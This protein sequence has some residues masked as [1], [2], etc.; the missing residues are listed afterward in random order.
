MCRVSPH[1][2]AVAGNPWLLIWFTFRIE[3]PAISRL[4]TAGYSPTPIEFKF[5]T[6]FTK[7]LIPL[8]L[9]LEK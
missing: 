3:L 1:R 4:A 2:P 7:K 5:A 6:F 8:S 9:Y